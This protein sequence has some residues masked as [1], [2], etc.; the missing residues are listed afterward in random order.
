MAGFPSTLH[1]V[2]DA[3]TTPFS[4]TAAS[5]V[6]GLQTCWEIR[7]LKCALDSVQQPLQIV[8]PCCNFRTKSCLSRS[9]CDDK[10]QGWSTNVSEFEQFLAFADCLSACSDLLYVACADLMSS[11]AV[12]TRMQYI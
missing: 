4:V 1:D 9:D 11:T 3:M 2:S 12:Y 7:L 6:L 5:F 10:Q 8:L